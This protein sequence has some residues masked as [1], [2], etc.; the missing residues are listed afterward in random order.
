MIKTE[1][2]AAHGIDGT[3]PEPGA[4]ARAAEFLRAG[5]LV[6]FPTETVYGLGAN[7]LSPEAVA[8]IFRAKG[9][10]AHNPV[11]VHVADIAVAR[12]LTADWPDFAGRLAAAFW[13]GPLTLVLPKNGLVPDIVTA[14][15]Q[16]VALRIPS[17][18]IALALLRA[19]GIPIAAPSANRSM[20]LSPTTAEH[21]LQS[22]D[23]RIDALLDGGPA[24]G[25]IESTVIS[26][27]G[28]RPR[29]LRPGL[30]TPAHIES[31]IG[32]I[33]RG[34]VVE[35]RGRNW[36]ACGG[37]ADESGES[38]SGKR[39]PEALASP[40]MLARHYAP[41]APLELSSEG[42]RRVRQ[43]LAEGHKVGWLTC[44]DASA[45]FGEPP[46]LLRTEMPRD[47]QAYASQLYAALHAL[48]ALG[49]SRIVVDELPPT[50][51]W[52]ALRD[53][54]QRASTPAEDQAP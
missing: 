43:L 41:L 47:P 31:I 25:G 33:E 9:R 35:I 54:L 18:P 12:A 48:D 40:G 50:D 10:P 53:R 1:R 21:V 49:V 26:L 38:E 51:D 4:I 3:S 32:A 37:L 13:P 44:S 29:L 24:T 20:L 42:E 7:A 23:G 22:L 39:T 15:G 17:H 45:D 36:Q 19:A 46:R 27:V 14:G 52:L 34:R 5:K 28:D 11:I 30:I 2:L 6:A 8:R 16:T